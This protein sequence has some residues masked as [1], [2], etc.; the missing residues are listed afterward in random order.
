MR[1][2][3]GK[4]FLRSFL[5]IALLTLL[6]PAISLILTFK[7]SYASSD[8][9]YIDIYI[10]TTPPNATLTIEKH[11]KYEG[12][13]GNPLRIYLSEFPGNST[14]ELKVQK[15]GYRNWQR[16][17]TRDYFKS[18]RHYPD[19]KNKEKPI[20]LIPATCKAVFNI[21][22]QEVRI[23]IEYYSSTK[24]VFIGV[25][26]KPFELEL[27]RLAEANEIRFIFES[28]F[29][30]SD[31]VRIKSVQF[32]ENNIFY[33][34]DSKNKNKAFHLKPIVPLISPIRH[35]FKYHFFETLIASFFSIL[36]IIA[37]YYIIAPP[38]RR[39]IADAR[40]MAAWKA[41]SR[42]VNTEDPMFKRTIGKYR[43]LEKIGTGGMATVYKAVPEE[44]LRE[45]DSVA[46]KIMQI[47]KVDSEEY[48]ERFKREMRISSEMNHQ[49]ILRIL[50]Y[51][52]EEGLLYIVMELVRGKPLRKFIPDEGFSFEAFMEY[53]KPTLKALIYAHEKGI[54][55]RDIK[56]DN[57]MV[58]DSNSIVVMDFGLARRQGGTMI[59]ASGV[60]IGTPAYMSPEQVK[61]ESLDDRTDQYSLGI[62]AFQMLTGQLPFYD[63]NTVNV[64]L[65]RMT[66]D[67]PPLREYRRDLP[68][69]LE[70]ILLRM[71][72]K[73]PEDRFPN[74]SEVLRSLE[75]VARRAKM[76]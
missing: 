69:I 40:K 42:R 25:A 21:A 53:F 76:G 38:I 19:I 22:P 47:D 73:E 3:T 29:Y 30:Y 35:N 67:P 26:G 49:N 9:E 71:L 70:K 18:H 54:V 50:D 41:A 44:T 55:H 32:D 63:E 66:E 4:V 51:G 57:L 10:H 37:L 11:M 45:E 36:A 48:C 43:I 39:H 59:T 5:R 60:A 31:E 17:F 20:E 28:D 24:P 34:P 52:D 13:T 2:T 7:T 8:P 1:R 46:I 15:K 62:M 75:E 64:M 6:M 68:E 23:F 65:K 27:P 16:G 72:E 14:I 56:P 58:T 61:G 33:F 12:T 74:L